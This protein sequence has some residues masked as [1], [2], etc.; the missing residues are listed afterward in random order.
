M[1]SGVIERGHCRLAGT[2]FVFRWDLNHLCS[3]VVCQ[4]SVVT[5]F[6]LTSMLYKLQL[7]I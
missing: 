7:Q 4:A 3:V 6:L 2:H 1:F 5:S